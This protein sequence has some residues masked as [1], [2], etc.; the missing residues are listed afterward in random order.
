VSTILILTEESE[1]KRETLK[2]A[3]EAEAPTHRSAAAIAA[4]L[5]TL[6]LH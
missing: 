1:R 2:E 4:H 6:F 5:A 3:A